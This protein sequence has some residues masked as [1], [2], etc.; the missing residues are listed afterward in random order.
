MMLSTHRSFF[1]ESFYTSPFTA[2]AHR[3]A[4]IPF[5]SVPTTTGTALPRLLLCVTTIETAGPGPLLAHRPVFVERA[6]C[7]PCTPTAGTPP[8]DGITVISSGTGSRC[9]VRGSPAR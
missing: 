3:R 6:I 4:C 7:M 5:S 8:L 1:R 9:A 2:Q